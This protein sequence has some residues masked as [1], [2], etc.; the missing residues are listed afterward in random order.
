[1]LLVLVTV[2]APTAAIL[3][4]S[5]LRAVGLPLQLETLSLRHYQELIFGVP[6]VRR[7]VVNSLLLAA[8]SATIIA[9]FSVVV[10]YLLVRLRIRGGQVLEGLIIVPYAIPGTVVALAM[11]LAF[12]RPLPLV[13]FSL[14][15]T[16]WIILLAYITRFLAFGVR[17]TSAA[18][19]QIDESLEE[20]AR[21]SG[22]GLVASIKDITVPLIKSGVFAGWFLA[23]IP[24]LTELTLSILLFSV[25]NETLGV[26]VFGLHQEGKVGLTAA[27]AFMVMI[28]VVVMNVLTRLATRGRLGF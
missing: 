10:A 13:E 23:F 25:G 14:Y 16:I 18:F 11:I 4:N 24:A 8:G 17:S 19:E 5:L 21:I 27:L 9:L 7:A 12:L 20:A 3:L 28:I 15:N 22:A 2:I 1:V 26:V 6:K